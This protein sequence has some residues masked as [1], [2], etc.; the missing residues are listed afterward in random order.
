MTWTKTAE[1]RRRDAQ[2]YS[3]PEYRR[4]RAL[5]VR[6]ARGICEGCDHKHPKLECD[7]VIPVSQGGGHDQANLRMVC[8]GSACQCHE[9]K[10]AQE[11]NGYR[12]AARDPAPVPR[13]Q[14]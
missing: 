7:H 6:R 10:T 8:K 1:D 5:A 3:T 13:T 12:R 11:S 2:V 14:W 4:N 9:K